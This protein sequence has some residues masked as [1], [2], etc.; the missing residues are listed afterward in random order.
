MTKKIKIGDIEEGVEIDNGKNAETQKPP[1]AL[2][3]HIEQQEEA[4]RK[5]YWEQDMVGAEC[6]KYK[7]MHR[8][9]IEYIQDE[10]TPI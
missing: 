5:Q 2:F 10:Y 3:A 8:K 1:Y 7:R 9:K 4:P 6:M